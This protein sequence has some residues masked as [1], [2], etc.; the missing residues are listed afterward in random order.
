[1]SPAA[2]CF[3]TLFTGILSQMLFR[4]LGLY[5]PAAALTIFYISVTYGPRV[6]I[7][8]SFLTAICLVGLCGTT[9]FLALL[10]LPGVAGFGAWWPYKTEVQHP[11]LS[12][13][14]G[15]LVMAALSLLAQL[16][17]IDIHHQWVLILSSLAVSAVAGAILM[18]VTVGFFDWI[19]VR[20]GLFRY[21]DA[22]TRILSRER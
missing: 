12:S 13:L 2:F 6:G 16:S 11:I 20:C 3:L 17:V 22:R 19:A 14:P 18:P 21:Q 9:D 1:M 10:C 7:I 15:I 8:C 4:I 5:I